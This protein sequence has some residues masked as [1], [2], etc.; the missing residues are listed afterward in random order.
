ML[1]QLRRELVSLLVPPLCAVCREPEPSGAPLCLECRTRLVPLS[2][3]RCPRCGAPVVQRSS[4][5]LECRGRALGFERAWSPFAYEGVARQIVAALKSRGAL[6]LAGL[7]AAEIAARAPAGLVEGTLVP[8]PAHPQRRRRHGFNQA[9]AIAHALARRASVPV[10]DLL[11]RSGPVTPQVGLERR[12]RLANARGSARVRRPS[13]APRR[14]V[15]VD[16][17]YTTGATLD[18]CARALSEAGA[19]LVVAVTFARAVR[20]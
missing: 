7:I 13:G 8:V 16:D 9:Q 15:L 20:G 18:A 12:A 17:V 2:D 11:R 3:P 19:D 6:V 1:D 14:A 5:C 4:D 10:R